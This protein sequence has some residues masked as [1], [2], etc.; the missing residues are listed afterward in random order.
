MKDPERTK[1]I[2]RDALWGGADLVGLGVASFSHVQGVH[3]QNLTE[4]DDYKKAIDTS[5]MPIKR[6]FQTNEE[7]RMIREFILQM[8]LG[9]VE[10]RYF[11]EKFGVN[12]LERF[13]AQLAELTEEGLLRVG[14]GSIDLDRDGLLCVDNLLHDFFL[15]HH[16]TDRIV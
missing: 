6:A 5:R 4:I 7:E 15:E 2:Y 11:E 16:K 10:A 1:F 3:Y 14:E 8:K 13:A 12:I 9:H